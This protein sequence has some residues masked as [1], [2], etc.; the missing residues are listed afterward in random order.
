MKHF[1]RLSPFGILSFMFVIPFLASCGGGSQPSIDVSD[2]PEELVTDYSLNY[3]EGKKGFM[4]EDYRG[5]G[6]SISIP[7]EATLGGIA[8]PIV[9]IS[10]Y[11]FANRSVQNIYLPESIHYIGAYAFHQS[12]LRNLYVTPYLTTIDPHALDNCDITINEKDGVRYLPSKK[13]PYGYAISYQGDKNAEITLPD[14]CEAVYDYVFTKSNTI[15]VGPAMRGFGSIGKGCQYTFSVPPTELVLTKAGDYCL[16]RQSDLASVTIDDCVTSIGWDA[17]AYCRSL[18]SITIPDSVTSIFPY[19]FTDCSSLASVTIGSGVTFITYGAFRGCTSLTS[20]T[21]GSGVTS[22]E[23]YAFSGCS[24][25]ASIVIPDSVTSIGEESFAYC[26]SLASI[27]IPDSVTFIG[28][29][30][31][32]RCSSLSSVIIPKS[33]VTI[34]KYAIDGPA[35]IYCEA[36]SKPDRWNNDWCSS[37]CQVVWGYQGN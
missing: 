2:A 35:T 27:T 22:I 3:Y 32:F 16:R 5:N 31:F 37:D 11:A 10:D 9:G 29:L 23:S 8:A 14:E 36:S 6:T 1:N 21:I 28:S 12:K 25:L 26:R 34:G 7:S 30:A 4:I 33:V 13:G 24:S 15:N 20:I 19:A 17:F 18:A